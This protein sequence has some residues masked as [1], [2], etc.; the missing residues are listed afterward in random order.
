MTDTFFTII[1]TFKKNC[2]DS[3]CLTGWRAVVYPWVSEMKEVY[4]AN[5]KYILLN[6]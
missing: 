2:D 3:G 1:V 4:S 5:S 6:V